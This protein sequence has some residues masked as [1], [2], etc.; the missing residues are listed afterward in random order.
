MIGYLARARRTSRS[1]SRSISLSLK[2]HSVT[3]PIGVIGRINAGS[4]AKWSD[5]TSTR[6]LKKRINESDGSQIDPRSVPLF[7][8]QT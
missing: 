4:R 6:G 2:I 8:L 1:R 7:R 5:H 3:L